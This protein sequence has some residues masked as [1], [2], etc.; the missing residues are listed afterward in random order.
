MGH[1]AKFYIEKCIVLTII[2]RNVGIFVFLPSK[3]KC[4]VVHQAGLGGEW[5]PECGARHE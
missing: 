3:A 4:V 5:G 1:I 2:T